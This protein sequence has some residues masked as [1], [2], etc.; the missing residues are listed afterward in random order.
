MCKLK[1]KYINFILFSH[2]SNVLKI[3]N[4]TTYF[5]KNIIVLFFLFRK[6][7][8]K[9][10]LK[11]NVIRILLLFLK[12][13]IHNQNHNLSFI[14]ETKLLLQIKNLILN[15]RFNFKQQKTKNKFNWTIKK[16]YLKIQF[17]KI[18]FFTLFD[19]IKTF[20]RNKKILYTFF[21]YYR[22]NDFDLKNKYF[23]IELINIYKKIFSYFL[24]KFIS[25]LFKKFKLVMAKQVK[26]LRKQKITFL[27]LSYKRVDTSFIINIQSNF[28]Y[29]KTFNKELSYFLRNKMKFILKHNWSSII[30]RKKILTFK[31]SK[32]FLKKTQNYFIFKGDLNKIKT[33]FFFLNYRRKFIDIKLNFNEY[34]LFNQF[35]SFIKFKLMLQ[36]LIFY[37]K[38]VKDKKNIILKIFSILKT[39]II[40]LFNKKFF[41]NSKS[42][43]LKNFNKDLSKFIKRYI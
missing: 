38:F 8:Y 39:S 17:N 41:F 31:G 27:A 3:L 33:R 21:E 43:I 6:I 20:V 24:D 22:F 16:E 34:F 10:N 18:N 36:S 13:R 32:M 40:K 15:L 7:K 26:K 29:I 5:T 37:Y 35:L 1:K 4:L 23:F 2:F 25:Y 19:I 30:N 9:Y 11:T 28:I 12:F 14:F 42:I